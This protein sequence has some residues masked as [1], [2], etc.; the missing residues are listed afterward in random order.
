MINAI[1]EI[2][3]AKP[4]TLGEISHGTMTIDDRESALDSLRIDSIRDG[5]TDRNREIEENL[6]PQLPMFRIVADV[7]TLIPGKFDEY[8]RQWVEDIRNAATGLTGND[9]TGGNDPDI[10]R[11][12]RR[13]P[14]AGILVFD[15]DCS[16]TLPL[17]HWIRRASGYGSGL[18]PIYYIGHV[19]KYKA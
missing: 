18:S 15:C 1:F 3:R 12:L 6:M 10:M 8:I 17:A 16:E 4:F 13:S 14:F 2:R 7:M 11:I 19:W 9:M 5:N